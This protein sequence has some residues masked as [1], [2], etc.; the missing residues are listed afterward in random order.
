MYRECLIWCVS[1]A[2]VVLNGF[3]MCGCFGNMC[4]GI[5]CVLYCLYCVF[6]LFRLCVSMLICLSVLVQGLL[7]SSGNSFA[8]NNNNNN[9]P[10]QVYLH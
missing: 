10:T 6:V 4:T 3:A 1:C 7:P 5:Y 9:I 8:V 2:V